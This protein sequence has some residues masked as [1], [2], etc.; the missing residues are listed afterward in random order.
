LGKSVNQ[1]YAAD[2][3]QIISLSQTR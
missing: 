3:F 2:K 1:E